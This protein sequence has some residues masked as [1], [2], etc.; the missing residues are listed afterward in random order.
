MA[1]RGHYLAQEVGRLAGVSGDR[2]GQWARRGYIRSSQSDGRPRV[3]SYQDVA[4][5]MV[6]HELTRREVALPAIKKTIERLRAEY[7]TDW[8]LAHAELLVP[9]PHSDAR[10]KH[11]TIVVEGIDVPSGQPV[12]A[13]IDLEEIVT[14]LSRGGW[15]AR[16]MPD[17]RHIEVDPDRMSGRPTI[18]G[19]RVPAEDVAELALSPD[20][21]AVLRDDY[22]LSEDEIRDAV[23]WWDAVRRYDAEAA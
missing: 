5:A 12:L 16:E 21:A 9:R 6:V 15:A 1:P 11:R 14:D 17:L 18:R 8:P 19:R 13:Q 23:R 22:D 7:G 4:E 10:G 2:V 20:G 3:Y